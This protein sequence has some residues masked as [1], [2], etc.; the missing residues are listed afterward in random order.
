MRECL[1]IF[2]GNTANSA[3]YRLPDG[4]GFPMEGE[5]Y[6]LLEI[7]YHFSVPPGQATD[8]SGIILRYTDPQPMEAGESC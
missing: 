5:M 1:S 6:L 8:N 3:P 7:H 2:W 4:V